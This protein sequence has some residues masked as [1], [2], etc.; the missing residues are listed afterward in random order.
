MMIS[1]SLRLM[2]F[3]GER[4]KSAGELLGEGRAAAAHVVRED[5]LEGALGGAEV[6]D[7]AVL[8]EVA[9]FDGDDGLH[10]ARRD[11]LVG[12]E[13]ALGAVLVFGERGDELRLEFVGAEGG[14]VFGG[15]ALDRRRRWC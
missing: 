8:E 9:V 11:L 6:V 10:H 2:R 13:A 5:V 1:I 14:S 15:D 12:D 7:A 3:S 4:K